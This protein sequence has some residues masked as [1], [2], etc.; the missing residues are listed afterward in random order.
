MKIKLNPKI[1]KGAGFH[2]FHSHTDI[3]PKK[4]DEIFNVPETPFI[5]QKLATGELILVTDDVPK[6]ADDDQKTDDKAKK[7]KKL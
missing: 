5:R 7:G 2:D 3:Y 1:S 4:P 6:P